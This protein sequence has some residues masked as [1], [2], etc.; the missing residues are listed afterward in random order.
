MH[1]HTH[2]HRDVERLKE[3]FYVLNPFAWHLDPPAKASKTHVLWALGAKS[4][5]MLC[6]DLHAAV[7]RMSL[8]GQP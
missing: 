5:V 1:T 6:L 3:G 4:I 7:L 8:E 2:T